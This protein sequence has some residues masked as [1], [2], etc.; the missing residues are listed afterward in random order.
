MAVKTMR[1][2]DALVLDEACL[3]P[4]SATCPLCGQDCCKDHIADA[5]I[6]IKVMVRH[7]AKEIG[8]L[9]ITNA[10]GSCVGLLGQLS[11]SAMDDT[12]KPLKENL[13]EALRAQLASKGLKP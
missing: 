4:Y 3:R 6:Q 13:V 5:A 2:C 10:C 12:L 8:G 11:I 7:A 1:V 9:S